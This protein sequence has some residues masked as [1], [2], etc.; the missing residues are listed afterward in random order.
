MQ[1]IKFR[2]IF[3][4]YG[5]KALTVL[6]LM[7]LPQVV[8]A[9]RNYLEYVNKK[10]YFGI[11]L[12]YNTSNFKLVQNSTFIDNDSVLTINSTHGPGFNLG[13]VSNLQMGKYFDLRF[14]PSLCFADKNLQYK[15][16]SGKTVEK[17][18]ESIIL[19]FPLEVRFKS[20]PI[21]DMRLY[22][23]VG[24]KYNL[25]LASNA[26]ARR[27]EDQVK[28]V[29]NDFAYE[30]GAGIQF[31]FPLFIFSPEIKFSNGLLNLHSRDEDFIYSNVL[32]KLLSRSILISL[33]FE[34]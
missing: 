21:K 1:N 32:D 7:V 17:S 14:I 6:L 16:A 9:Q 12:G 24:M 25:D 22:V 33:H 13:I 23:L 18:I 19:E 4:L 31:F 15:M 11:T 27:A 20:Q 26:K 2:Y 34:G 8:S 3:H 30:Y 10:I 28:I 29:A 5:P